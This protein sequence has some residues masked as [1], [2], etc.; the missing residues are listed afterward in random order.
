MQIEP[1]NLPSAHAIEFLRGKLRS[2]PDFPKPGIVFKD[3]TPLLGDAQALNVTLDLMT[4]PFIGQDIRHVV[5]M[6]ARGFIFG[7]AIAARLQAGFVPVRKPGKLPAATD[8]VRYSLEY[9]ES[10]LHMHHD[11]LAT[12]D[13]VLIVD[14]LLATGGTAKATGDLVRKQGGRVAAYVFVVELDFLAG[15]KLLRDEG[16]AAPAV[17][18]LIHVAAGE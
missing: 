16:N 7:A 9:G 11:A 6:E 10:E 13:R 2:I 1:T 12:D 4:L 8:S 18:S 14:D 3:I 15:R 5:A 17:Y